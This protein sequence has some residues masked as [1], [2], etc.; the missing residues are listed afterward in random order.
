MKKVNIP[1]PSIFVAADFSLDDPPRLEAVRQILVSHF[2]EV[3]PARATANLAEYCIL[4]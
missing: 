4:L 2:R 1:A 3:N